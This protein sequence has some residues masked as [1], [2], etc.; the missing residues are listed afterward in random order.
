VLAPAAVECLTQ[1]FKRI[2]VGVAAAPALKD[3]APAQDTSGDIAVQ[4]RPGVTPRGARSTTSL[5]EGEEAAV[6]RGQTD[7]GVVA[8]LGQVSPKQAA[9]GGSTEVVR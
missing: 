9:S 6:P 8:G 3:E 4:K 7:T 2:P 1:C 5:I